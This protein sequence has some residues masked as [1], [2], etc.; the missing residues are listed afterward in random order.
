L[1]SY[2]AVL[3]KPDVPGAIYRV[4]KVGAV[5]K[6][7]PANPTLEAVWATSRAELAKPGSGLPA[8][9][10][11]LADPDETV[12][13]ASAHVVGLYRDKAAVPGLLKLLASGTAANKRA[14]AEALGRVGDASAVGP[15]L[16]AHR[17]HVGRVRSAI[18]A[19]RT[20][21]LGGLPPGVSIVRRA[22]WRRSGHGRS[23]GSELRDFFRPAA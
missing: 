1:L 21:G 6:R 19:A 3:A 23:T 17:G 20:G 4:R 5:P 8:A 9:R 10:S 18:D 15:L 11:A 12:R 22:D 2:V 14:A 16:T 7:R 13:Q